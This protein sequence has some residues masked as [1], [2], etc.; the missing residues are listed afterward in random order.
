ML[1]TTSKYVTASAPMAGC[2]LLVL[3]LSTKRTVHCS[4]QQSRTGKYILLLYNV[5]LLWCR[6]RYTLYIVQQQYTLPWCNATIGVNNW[7]TV[8]NMHIQPNICFSRFTF[9]WQI[10]ITDLQGWNKLFTIA[11]KSPVVI[12]VGV[13]ESSYPSQRGWASVWSNPY[14]QAPNPPLPCLSLRVPMLR[15]GNVLCYHHRYGWVRGICRL[16]IFTPY[17]MLIKLT[18]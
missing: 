10:G 3:T 13:S 15:R 9:S 7:M 16:G 4:P 14:N 17:L 2:V 11:S 12:A 6:P 1:W 18:F 8:Q 5:Q